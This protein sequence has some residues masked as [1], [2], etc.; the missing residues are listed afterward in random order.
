VASW[1]PM[2]VEVSKA[3]Q[4]ERMWEEVKVEQRAVV[5]ILS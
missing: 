4:F 1:V 5:R 3:M 2:L